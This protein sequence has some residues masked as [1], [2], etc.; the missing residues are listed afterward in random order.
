MR[1]GKR[2]F[3]LV[4]AALAMAVMAGCGARSDDIQIDIADLSREL[5][6]KG[7]FEDELSPISDAAIQKLY[8]LEDYVSAEVYV[9][10]G[11]TAEEIALFE[12]DSTEAAA[13]GLKQAQFRIE[14]QRA[15]FESYIPQEVPKLDRAV[16]EQLGRYVV[17]CVSDGDAAEEALTEYINEQNEG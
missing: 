10:S 14:G 6:E 11:A 16:V 15:D 9:S 8:G 12:F 5:R 7:E 4:L 17:V 2:L 3:A 1:M 13:G